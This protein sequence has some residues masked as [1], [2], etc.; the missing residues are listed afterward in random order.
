MGKV[1]FMPVSRRSVL[2][3]AAALAAPALLSRT[4]KADERCVV[5]TWGGDY[6]RLLREN[7][8]DPI[9]KPAGVEVVQAVGDEAPRLA[10]LQA[11]RQL[12]RGALDISCLGALNGSVAANLNLLE[13]LDETKVPN[14]KH[15]D[16]RL[17]SGTFMPNQF[18]PHI[19]SVQGIAYNP[20][21]VKDPPKKLADLLDPKWKGKVGALATADK[22]VIQGA[23][24]A[25]GGSSNDFDKGKE[26]L[27]KLNAN[28]LRVY[29]QT[30]DMA[31]AFKSGEIEVGIVWLA[32]T[33][34]WQNAEFPVAGLVPEEGAIIYISGM[35]VPKN[36]PDKE[37]AFKYMNALLEPS[38]QRGFAAHMG[39]IPTVNDAE[40]AGKVA[41]QLALPTDAKLVQPDYAKVTAASADL[42]DWWLK[43][44]LRK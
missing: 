13:T 43:N 24:L 28:G 4:A 6:A 35:V 19:W 8:D 11:Q 10:Q 41:E 23:A 17:H 27:L 29:P 32:R 44:I 15:V 2:A 3:G 30:D 42:N 16:A 7:I 33:V 31:P 21:T 25:A 34:M 14:L 5:G 20:Q 39:Y 26:F 40:L 1:N 22:W 18:V 38:A 9:L 36:A 12:P 37:T